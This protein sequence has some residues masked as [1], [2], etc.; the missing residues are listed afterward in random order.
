M[1]CQ[2]KIP[3]P[4]QCLMDGVVYERRDGLRIHISGGLIRPQIGRFHFAKPRQMIRAI[5]RV[6]GSRRRALM[7]IATQDYPIATPE[8]S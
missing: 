4:W 7:L 8:A 5:K 3:G 6:G 2:I 1:S